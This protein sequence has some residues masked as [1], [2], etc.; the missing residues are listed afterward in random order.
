[1]RKPRHREIAELTQAESLFQIGPC[2]SRVALDKTTPTMQPQFL[3]LPSVLLHKWMDFLT[4]HGSSC[5]DVSVT[6]VP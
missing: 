5:V 4:H 1:M 6:G 2:G 3:L